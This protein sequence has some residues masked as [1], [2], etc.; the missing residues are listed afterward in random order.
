MSANCIDRHVKDKGDKVALL[1]QGDNPDDVKK[2]TYAS[3]LSEVSLM[4]NILL[5][6][7][8]QKGDRVTI[9]MPMIP[10]AVFAMLAC[11]RMGAIHSVVFGGFSAR[12]LGIENTRCRIY[13]GYNG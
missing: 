7:G 13:F 11:A 8:V 6:Y 5:K 2:I 1:W 4:A 3:L 12:V 10:E 9:Y